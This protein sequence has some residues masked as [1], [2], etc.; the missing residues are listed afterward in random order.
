MKQINESISETI[1]NFRKSNDCEG[2]DCFLKCM[3]ELES[4][5]LNDKYPKLVQNQMDRINEIMQLILMKIKN[6]DVTGLTDILEFR[7]S[8]LINKCEEGERV[9]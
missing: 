2:I 4:E 9:Q 8:P 6:K 5:V 1:E 7:L 3:N